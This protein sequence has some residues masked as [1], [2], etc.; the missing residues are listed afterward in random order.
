MSKILKG[1]NVEFILKIMEFFFYEK[2]DFSKVLWKKKFLKSLW[3][4]EIFQLFM[5][6]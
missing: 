3:K 1:F 4:G 2:G 6:K 5:K